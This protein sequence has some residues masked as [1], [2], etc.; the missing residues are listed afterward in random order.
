MKG[1]VRQDKALAA[2][3]GATMSEL[4]RSLRTL[5]PPGPIPALRAL[6]AELRDGS[7]TDP[8]LLAVTDG[9]V[10]AI[11]TIDGILRYHRGP[12]TNVEA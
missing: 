10:D 3:L 1:H 9:L 4:A 5:E 7:V 6:Q 8:R 11:Y 2:A 12:P